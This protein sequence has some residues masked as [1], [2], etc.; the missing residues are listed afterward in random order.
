MMFSPVLCES[1]G[2]LWLAITYHLMRP[3]GAPSSCTHLKVTQWERERLSVFLLCP[4]SRIQVIFTPCHL[5]FYMILSLDN[6][7]RFLVEATLFAQKMQEFIVTVSPTAAATEM[8]RRSQ[9]GGEKFPIHFCSKLF[10]SINSRKLSNF[11]NI[12]A[13]LLTLKAEVRVQEL[14][15]ISP[16]LLRYNMLVVMLSTKHSCGI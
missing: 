16:R 13:E 11:A 9:N 8:L 2:T 12:S 5:I 15:F 4:G 3:V 10:Q 6:G 1:L 7:F 14:L